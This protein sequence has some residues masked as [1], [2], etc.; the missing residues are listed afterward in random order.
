MKLVAEGFPEAQHQTNA[1]GQ[2]LLITEKQMR[3][4]DGPL[5]SVH[6]ELRDI[7]VPGPARIIATFLAG[8][9]VF[10]G[11]GFAYTSASGSGPSPAKDRSSRAELL[12]RIEELEQ[13]RAAE[14][15]GPKTYDRQRRLLIDAL[16]RLLADP[17]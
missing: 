9:G 6:V 8:L 4:E 1:Q 17:A 16:A 11:L 7:P 10:L 5:S 2:K 14:E 12:E 15:I 3:R 13:A